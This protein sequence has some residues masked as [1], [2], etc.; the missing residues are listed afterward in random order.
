M[1]RRADGPRLW[2]EKA[3]RD[4]DGNLTHHARWCIKDRGR[5]YSTGRSEDDRRGAE[6]ALAAYIAEKHVTG[7]ASGVRSPA[8]I[9]LADVV[10]LYARHIGGRRSTT[11]TAKDCARQSSLW[12]CRPKANRAD[13]GFHEVKRRD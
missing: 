12:C 4:A 3:Q 9:P 2:L 10:A 1:P 8:A 13:A 5:K 6:K 7:A 11:I